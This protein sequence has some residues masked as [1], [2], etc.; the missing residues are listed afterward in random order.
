MKKSIRTRF[1]LGM[2][3][4]FLIILVLSVFSDYLLNKLSNKTSAILK[5]NYVSI[6]YAREMSEGIMNINQE[7][8]SCFLTK[9]NS[10]SLKINSDLQYINTSLQLEI[11]NITEPG[12]EKLVSGIETGFTEYRDSVLKFI[13][14]P[15]SAYRILYLENKSG[16]LNQQLLLLS[17]MNGKALEMK[18]D[19]AKDS[20]KSAL[21]QMTILATL[22]F[23]MG[24]SFTFSFASYFNQRFFQLY[25]GIKEIVSS[26]YNQKL[27]F[28]G[29]D[30]FY[31]ISV[32]F[33]EMAERLK[34]NKQKMSVTLQEDMVK[35]ISSNDVEELQ[36]MLFRLKVMEEQAAALIS[37]FKQ[38]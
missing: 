17:Q 16:N 9:R 21:T 34:E 5:E 38:K 12:E 30:E 13:L 36:K 4:L 15:L 24:M 7:L 6:V 33:N 2:I 11:K 19:D 1:T 14:S 28:E 29:K 8:T 35:G 25:N 20:S 10:D 3:F 27:F 31:E 32:L 23:L 18:T 26:N 22:C 37:R